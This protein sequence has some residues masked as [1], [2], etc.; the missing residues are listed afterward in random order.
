M[1]GKRA[2][3]HISIH[4]PRTGSDIARAGLEGGG[5]KFQS[6][7][8]ARGATAPPMTSVSPPSVFQ[9]TLPARGAT[10]G[11]V[12][13][14]R[15]DLD[16]NPR[17]PHGERHVRAGFHVQQQYISIHAPRTGSDAGAGGRTCATRYFNPRSPHGERPCLM[18][19]LR[20]FVQFQ[21]TLP[22]RGATL[23][24]YKDWHDISEFQSTLPARGATAALS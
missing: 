19:L 7:L 8:P 24:S 13:S 14:L 10:A 15:S 1:A 21:S 11:F 9:S 16:F 3:I 22:A 12:I 17:S 2:G 6:T 23:A 18:L 20:R 4:A 5:K